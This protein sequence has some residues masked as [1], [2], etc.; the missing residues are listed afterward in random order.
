MVS[1]AIKLSLQ[2]WYKNGLSTRVI[3]CFSCIIPSVQ[4]AAECR[5]FLFTENYDNPLRC[6]MFTSESLLQWFPFVQNHG[7]PISSLKYLKK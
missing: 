1:G 4:L 7:I 6:E 3:N 5:F 2:V